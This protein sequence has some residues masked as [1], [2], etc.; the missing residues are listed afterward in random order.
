MNFIDWFHRMRQNSIFAGFLTFLVITGVALSL[1]FL[2]WLGDMCFVWV[3]PRGHSSELLL[4]VFESVLG[5]LLLLLG[6]VV[7]SLVF[8]FV[9]ARVGALYTYIKENPSTS[10]SKQVNLNTASH[11]STGNEP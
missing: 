11:C 7:L 5:A 9:A 4:Y 3:A 6:G 2:F 8:A 10:T 1:F